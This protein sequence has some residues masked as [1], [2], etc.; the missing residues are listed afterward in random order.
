MD[1]AQEGLTGCMSST[2]FFLPGYLSKP[3]QGHRSEARQQRLSP[4]AMVSLVPSGGAVQLG[5]QVRPV[6]RVAAATLAP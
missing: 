5:P 2:P 6:L 4:H 3:L 1:Q